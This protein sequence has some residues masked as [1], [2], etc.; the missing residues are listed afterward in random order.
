M[1]DYYLSNTIQI[2]VEIKSS[3]SWWIKDHLPFLVEYSMK[4]TTYPSF[5]GVQ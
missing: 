2:K 5:L 4:Q 3:A 1:L